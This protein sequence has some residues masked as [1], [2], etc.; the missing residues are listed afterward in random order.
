[1]DLILSMMH[2][3]GILRLMTAAVGT[4]LVCGSALAVS[5]AVSGKAPPAKRGFPSVVILEAATPVKSEV[6]AEP[7]SMD[8]VKKTFTPGVVVARTGQVVRFLNNDAFL[9]NVHV[10]D[11]ANDETIFNLSIPGGFT[12]GRD[13]KFEK[14]G[15]YVVLCDVHPEMEAYIVITDSPYAAVTS[16]EGTFEM[17]NVPSGAYTARVWNVDEARRGTRSVTIGGAPTEIDLTGTR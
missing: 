16:D 2:R 17:P 9:H 10:Y 1:M 13:W 5:S 11:L 4:L 15:E 6:P 12:R 3:S 7:V 8:Q 14:A